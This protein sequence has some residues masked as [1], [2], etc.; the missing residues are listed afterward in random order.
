MV[1]TLPRI[2]EVSAE[3][4]HHDDAVSVFSD[5]LTNTSLVAYDGVTVTPLFA[6]RLMAYIDVLRKQRHTSA[7]LSAE[8]QSA[9]TGISKY[10]K[11][12][13]KKRKDRHFLIPSEAECLESPLGLAYGLV[14]DT[15]DP[16]TA[17]PV[18]PPLH[19]SDQLPGSSSVTAALESHAAARPNPL[20]VLVEAASVY[21]G[22]R[23]SMGTNGARLLA[24][25]QYDVQA[26][27]ADFEACGARASL[28]HRDYLDK[29][30]AAVLQWNLAHKLGFE[31]YDALCTARAL[32]E[33]LNH[34]QKHQFE[35][36]QEFDE[37]STRMRQ[38]HRDDFEH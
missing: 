1:N 8:E 12:L 7:I 36:L 23:D 25:I 18:S 5:L 29:Q 34:R 33:E 3:S 2:P 20:T 31:A 26:H 22:F 38:H 13:R 19:A 10:F 27:Q 21:S 6:E 32:S 30:A 14:W 9:F 16:S 35:L 37:C 11:N 4:E 15:S 17:W 28:A 24:D